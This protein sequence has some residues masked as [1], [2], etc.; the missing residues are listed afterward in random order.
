M[1]KLGHWQLWLPWLMFAAVMLLSVQYVLGLVTRSKVI[2]SGAAMF[3]GRV[4]VGHARVSIVDRHIALHDVC[5]A[6]PRR[7]FNN[8]V[9]GDRCEFDVAAGPLLHKRTVIERGSVTGLRFATPRDESGTSSKSRSAV[10]APSIQW[11]NDTTNQQ[12]TEW[13]ELLIRRFDPRLVNQ[14]EAIKQT[15]ALDDRVPREAAALDKRV[16]ELARRAE[17]LQS[18]VNRALANP[19]RN[20][21]FLQAIAQEVPALQKEF[22]DAAAEME[23]L[24][25]S[26]DADRR[27]IVAAR[28]N[29]E[30][31]L[32][33]QLQFPPL[34]AEA[35]TAYLLQKQVT[36][37]VDEVI[38]LLRVIRQIV[39]AKTAASS[40]AGQRGED[41]L[42]A[43]CERAPQ[44]L[45]RK[46]VLAG[47]A[48]IGSRR[49]ELRGTLSDYAF[50]PALHD[51]PLRVK[52]TS[53][54]SVP[55][56]L[57]AT[58]DRL[59]ATAHDELA[60][61]CQGIV[62]PR[63]ELGE[64][65]HLRLELA[66]SSGA[67]SI[68]LK[69]D[70]DALSGEIELV[71]KQVQITPSIGRDLSTVPITAA[72]DDALGNVDALATRITISGTLAQPRCRL[73]S[74][75]GP[76]VAEGMDRALWRATELHVRRMMSNAERQV[77]QRFT[78]LERQVAEIQAELRP[79]LAQA[80]GQVSDIAARRTPPQRITTER[81]GRR[82]PANSLFQ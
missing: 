34:E 69:L 11:W 33:D 2:D 20:A 21:E 3:G 82:L 50:P 36:A 47:M 29:D 32:R 6:D 75:L 39:P 12:P 74:D 1:S 70:G 28:R 43:G 71:Q 15:S 19:L 65:E 16:R 38:D 13:L 9:E 62:L 42:F 58:V 23:R 51:Q 72:L 46:L 7:P 40:P 31:W 57:Q 63:T 26:I 49:V 10:A 78:E 4:D 80:A 56:E 67:L 61:D 44:L 81:V 59:G 17:E 76:V 79:Q 41:I 45:V 8:L 18:K 5:V 66:P 68:R 52:L 30:A 53:L 35:L 27:A 64:S 73:T 60:I 22:A 77:D 25:D 54:G 55:F 37:P 24:P 14:F 48:T